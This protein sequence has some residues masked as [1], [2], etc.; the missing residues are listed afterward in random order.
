MSQ[1]KLGVIGYGKRI[2][3]I[4]KLVRE[5]CPDAVVTAVADIRPEAV[6]QSM[7]DDGV[8]MGT[9]QVFEDADA[10]LGTVALDG[11]LVG[12]RCDMHTRMALKVMRHN[13]PIFLEKPIATSMSDLTAIVE[14]DA[15]YAGQAVV[16]FPMRVSGLVNAVRDIVRS[17]KIGRVSQVQA[18]NNVPYGAV[19]FQD[20]YRDEAITGGLFLQKAT[21]DF[22]YIHSLLDDTPTSICAMTSKQVFKG[23]RRAGLFCK[24]CG[25]KS[26]CL[27][28]PFNPGI[29]LD[30]DWI[31]PER[32]QCAFAIDTGNEDSG[33]ALIR[34][35]SGMHVSY[36]QNFV[37]RKKAARRGATLI[38]Y[39]GTLEFDWFTNTIKVFMHHTNQVETV[40]VDS[41][42]NAH[43][44][45]DAILARNFVDVIRDGAMSITPLDT[46]L[47]STLMCLKAKESAESRTFQ[48]IVYPKPSPSAP[49]PVRAGEGIA[50]LSSPGSR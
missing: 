5:C 24:E 29:V 40:E 37:A 28:S 39:H 22:D 42:A 16:S 7:R 11:V 4:V 49:S 19:Y 10:M 46:G 20:W 3:D 48:E 44:G 9:A 6:R 33:S 26:T 30:N 13:M 18:V 23:D 27:Q 2:R 17:G 41:A 47:M 14:A 8:D 32:R 12:T 36:S 31:A 25:E 15:T 34:Y 35:E 50:E 45:G 1:V 38:G 43:G 21:H